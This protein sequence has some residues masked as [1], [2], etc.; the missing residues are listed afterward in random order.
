LHSLRSS[1]YWLRATALAFAAFISLL[2]AR[3]R[4]CIRCAHL[5]TGCALPRLHSLRSLDGLAVF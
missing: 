4:A 2:A 5:I 1:H 3:Y